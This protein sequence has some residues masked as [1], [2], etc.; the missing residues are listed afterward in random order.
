MAG[1]KKIQVG[2]S[3]WLGLGHLSL[4][5][6][7]LKETLQK[8]PPQVEL[9]VLDDLLLLPRHG[10]W[11]S[12]GALGRFRFPFRNRSLLERASLEGNFYLRVPADAAPAWTEEF[13]RTQVLVAAAGDPD[14]IARLESV[15][16]WPLS[17]A[18]YRL[19][20]VQKP[21]R[22]ADSIRIVV[23]FRD[24]ADL[25]CRLLDDLAEQKFTAF[26]AELALINNQSKPEELEKVALR[27]ARLPAPWKVEI[28]DYDLPYNHSAQSNL[29]VRGSGCEV[30]FFL[31][32]DATLHGTNVIQGLSDWCLAPNV[33]TAGPRIVGDR[34]LVSAGVQIEPRSDTPTGVGLCESTCPVFSTDVRPTSGNS[35]ACAAVKAE[36]F[37]KLGGL[38]EVN[39]PTQ[40]NDADFFLRASAQGLEHTLVG[41]IEVFHQPGQS[42]TRTAEQVKASYHS[43]LRRHPQIADGLDRDPRLARLKP[44]SAPGGPAKVVGNLLN[45]S[46]M[47]LDW[48]RKTLRAM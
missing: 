2:S 28:L 1:L 33:A 40:Y 26:R 45:G 11:R 14:K 25:T 27:T 15:F 22:K 35:F 23:C 10:R 42:D 12:G 31:N 18:P 4:T 46:G 32:N 8:L 19:N 38:D 48:C 41:T 36:V 29:G 20:E 24:R 34:G 21:E 43:L 7:P 44:E 17:G 37:R 39:F 6:G 9:A 13:W 30:F 47:A 16:R 5:T 3:V